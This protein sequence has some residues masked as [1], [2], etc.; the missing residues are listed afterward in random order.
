MNLIPKLYQN[1]KFVKERNSI[2]PL[3]FFKDWRGR[4]QR[5]RESQAGSKPGAE[6]DA[7]LNLR[8]SQNLRYESQISGSEIM[9]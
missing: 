9:T 2:G 8:V 3:F 1:I 4:E 7:E 6:P 5:G